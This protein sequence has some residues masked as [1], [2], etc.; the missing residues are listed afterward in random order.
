[1]VPGASASSPALPG[2]GGGDASGPVIARPG[3]EADT[4]EARALGKRT[5]SPMGS[6]AAVEQVAAGATQLPPQRTDGAPGSVE[7]RPAPYLIFS[8][9]HP[10]EVPTLAPL[11]ALKVRPSSTAHWVVEAQ[12]T[13]QHGAA[14]A[15]A[16]PKEPVAQ[17]GAAEATPTQTGEGAPPSREAEAR[18]LDGAKAPSVTEATEVKA[19]WASEA[20]ATE[21][22]APR[23]AE[24]A[25]AGAGA[26]GTTEADV[27]AAKPSAQ[28]VEM[29]A[30]EASVAPLVL[31]LPLLRGSV[32]EAEVHPISSD[33]T[34]QAQEVVD[35][36]V[37]GFVEQPAPTLGEGSSALVW[38]RPE[39]HGWD[40]SHVLWQSRDDPEGEPLFALEDAAEGGRWDTF[41]Q[42]R[43]LAERSLRTALSMVADD[44]PGVA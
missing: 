15:R 37:A 1:M 19:P 26:P 5:V 30:V 32:R 2:G 3:V 18:E 39:P 24:A 14:S 40:H 4:P 28:A 6:T 35:A 7:D 36:E 9:K 23:T 42:Y 41:E 8:Q 34:S 13:I 29:K 31:G 44:L 25:A 27:I 12:A 21:A 22:E 16:D 17:G 20:E 38:V 10:T 11:K 43:Q 33:D